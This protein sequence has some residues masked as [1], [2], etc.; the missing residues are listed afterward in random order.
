MQSYVLWV[1]T[2]L[3]GGQCEGRPSKPQPPPP[4][5]PVAPF[6]DT[7]SVCELWHLSL[8]SPSPRSSNCLHGLPLWLRVRLNSIAIRSHLEACSPVPLGFWIC[9]WTSRPSSFFLEVIIFTAMNTPLHSAYR[10]SS[11]WKAPPINTYGFGVP[12][13]IMEVKEM[14]SRSW[15]L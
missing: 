2:I 3:E 5:L 6:L 12:S 8:L 4:L 7:A 15:Y 11:R 9:N 14:N 10:W 1:T 13:T